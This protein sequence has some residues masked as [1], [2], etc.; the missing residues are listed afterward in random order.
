MQVMFDMLEL[1]KRIVE[2]VVEVVESDDKSK[3][4]VKLKKLVKLIKL[5]IYKE[6][7]QNMEKILYFPVVQ[8]LFRQAAQDLPS[9]G[10]K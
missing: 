7:Q 5:K 10:K 2:R 9:L 4:L 3:V 6:T 8:S 1:N